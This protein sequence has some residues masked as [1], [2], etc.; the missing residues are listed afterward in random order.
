MSREIT[1][2]LSFKLFHFFLACLAVMGRPEV[3]TNSLVNEKKIPF[4]LPNNNCELCQTIMY[5]VRTQTH[6][7]LTANCLWMS[8]GGQ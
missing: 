1:L 2:Y 8:C 7:I 4:Q 5:T 6:K 3:A